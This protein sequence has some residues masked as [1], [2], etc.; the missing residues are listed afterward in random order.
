MKH[1]G[2][3]LIFCWAGLG[4][5]SAAEIPASF[6]ALP[7][8]VVLFPSR[9]A[10]LSARLEGVIG[11]QHF[12]PGERFRGGDVLVQ[13][14]EDRYRN[15][16]K[17]AE[18]I[19]REAAGNADFAREQLT[20]AKKLFSQDFQSELELKRR[21]L[22]LEVAESRLAVAGSAVAE[23][24]MQ[25]RFCTVKAPF[26]GR[27]EQIFSR[28]F[29]TVRNGQ[30][31]LGII[32]DDELLAVMNLPA[33]ALAEL[34]VGMPVRCRI[35]ETGTVVEGLVAEIAARADHRSETVEVKARV[36]NPGHRLA[37]GMSGTLLGYGRALATAKAEAIHD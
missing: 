23:A 32:C 28:D 33:G 6:E 3:L 17:K 8:K 30:P 24:A 34:K 13:M 27:V 15:D 22:E 26:S 4:L 16:F 31:L 5:L 14:E 29:E 19:R 36:A 7:V 1:R 21:T 9:E 35:Q 37:A 12:R 2:L 11:K 10:V 18:A 25:L 20:N